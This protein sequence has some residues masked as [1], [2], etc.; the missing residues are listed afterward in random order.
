MKVDAQK[1]RELDAA[2]G[3]AV[4]ARQEPVFVRGEGAYVWDSEGKKYLDFL[5]GIAV[6]ALGHAHPAL[7][8]AIHEQA[9]TL[10]HMSN[11]FHTPYVAQ[12]ARKLCGLS[13]FDR[14]FFCN[15]GAEANEA[16]IKL[17]RKFGKA[18]SPDKFHILTAKMSFHGRTMA[19][20]AATGQ[21]KFQKP[22]T[23]MLEGFHHI[24]FNDEKALEA[25]MHDKVCAVML[26]PIQGESGVNVGTPAFLQTARKL[27]DDFGALLIFDEVQTGIAR[28]GH[29]FAFQGLQIQPDVITLA[30]GLGGGFPVG[31]CLARGDA[32]Q[33]LQLGDH[34]TTF[35]GNPLATRVALTVLETIEKDA[36]RE[37]AMETGA[38]F[39]SQAKAV[40]GGSVKEVRG[41]G[42][43]IGLELTQPIAK[44]VLK[45]ALAKGLIVNA[46]G[47]QV[48]RLLPP[49][50]ITKAQ[51]DEALQILKESID[52]T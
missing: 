26:E 30:K 14:A 42:L 51:C 46:V 38:Y 25:A 45:R 3:F 8:A 40:L 23:P 20:V 17:A 5:S 4:Y 52:Q 32:A 35:G 13:G 27:C 18:K 9:G 10:M 36:L 43:M 37:N 7:V 28:T 31:A 15:S 24:P 16:A 22:F 11:L 33:T 48:I 41:E 39:R 29:W 19:T 34:G 1:I 49:L 44:D 2:Y 12:L 6:N 47:E 50:I 21:E